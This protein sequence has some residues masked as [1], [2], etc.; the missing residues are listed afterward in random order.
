MDKNKFLRTLSAGLMKHGIDDY[1]DIIR[2]YENHFDSELA[3]GKTEEEIAR[4][5]GDIKQIIKEYVQ[6]YD[7]PKQ[8]PIIILGLTLQDLF[9]IP[10]MILLYAV[11]IVLAV[12]ALGFFALGIYLLLGMKSFAFIPQLMLPLNFLYGLSCFTLAGSLFGLSML[13]FVYIN[14]A[15]RASIMWQKS[16]LSERYGGVTDYVP[17][18]DVKN[19]KKI[20]VYGGIA[21]LALFIITYVVS[22][23]MA[24][25]FQFW[26]TWHWFD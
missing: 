10:L 12:G 4:E 8:K 9:L 25:S 3:K 26:H 22:A 1:A 11:F 5:L 7:K 24:G 18:I 23:L 16:L 6:N 14:K 15:V 17:P 2:D 21:F 20:T 19:Y 13:Y